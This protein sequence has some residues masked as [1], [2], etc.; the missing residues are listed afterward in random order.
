[1]PDDVTYNASVDDQN[2]MRRPSTATS[3]TLVGW[4]TTYD[5]PS[6]KMETDTTYYLNCLCANWASHTSQFAVH[7]L[8]KFK[9]LQK[10]TEASGME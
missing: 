1:M 5:N 6:F 4:A 8:P 3:A 2:D 10:K 7:A 9:G